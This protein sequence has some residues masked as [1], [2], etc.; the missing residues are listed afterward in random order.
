MRRGLWQQAKKISTSHQLYH[1][2]HQEELGT[3][4]TQRSTAPRKCQERQVDCSTR[5]CPQCTQA[6]SSGLINGTAWLPK[7]SFSW[8]YIK[9]KVS[10]SR[11]VWGHLQ[12]IIPAVKETTIKPL[13]QERAMCSQGTQNKQG[14][15]VFLFQIYTYLSIMAAVLLTSQNPCWEPCNQSIILWA[16]CHRKK[17]S[18]GELIKSTDYLCQ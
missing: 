7:P 4:M 1:K 15:S 12:A 10:S 9:T 17:G 13:M 16:E 11:C 6:V 5:S 3:L 2:L 8:N 18:N 14:V